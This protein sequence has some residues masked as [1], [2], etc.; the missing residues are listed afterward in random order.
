MLVVTL[1]NESRPDEVLPRGHIAP[2]RSGNPHL[3]T[4]SRAKDNSSK[5]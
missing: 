1:D 3:N 2:V 5:I 4:E